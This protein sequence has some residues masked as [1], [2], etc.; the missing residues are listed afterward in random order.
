[1]TDRLT[2]AR[3]SLMGLAV[4]DALGEALDT[5][6][7]DLPPAPWHWTDDTEMACS[8]VHVLATRGHLDAAALADSFVARYDEARNY[9]PGVDAMIREV[10]RRGVSLARLATETFGGDGSWGT[11]AAMRVAPL[12][13]WYHDDPELAAREA[14]AS[15]EVTHTHPEGVAGAVAT[16]VAASLAAAG[17]TAADL[18]DEVL[19]RTPTGKVYDGLRD[20]ADLADASA[21]EAAATLGDGARRSAPDTVPLALWVAAQHLDDYAAAV[22]AAAPVADDVDTVCAIVGGIV[23]GRLGESAIPAQWRQACEP[24]PAWIRH[25]P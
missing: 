20:A 6:G 10:S 17:A 18:L 9:G 5:T 15:A 4:G 7:L 3:A 16:A 22:R 25:H 23:A 8:V 19:H 13:A 1:M 11:G 2:P 14:V 12:G 21:G 24:L